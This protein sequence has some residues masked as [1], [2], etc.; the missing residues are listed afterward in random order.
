MGKRM[1]FIFLVGMLCGAMLL[2][3][4]VFAL[5][6]FGDDVQAQSSATWQVVGGPEGFSIGNWGAGQ[7]PDVSLDEWIEIVPVECDIQTIARGVSVVSA[8]YRCP[9]S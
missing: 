2:G 7:G 1:V 4:G 3:G 8:Y 6:H 5:Q 9:E